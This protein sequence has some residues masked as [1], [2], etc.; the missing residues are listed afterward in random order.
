MPKIKVY[1]THENCHVLIHPTDGKLSDEGS[2]WEYDPFTARLLDTND[3]TRDTARAH[4]FAADKR[5]DQSK[6]PAHATYPE[7]VAATASDDDTES[8]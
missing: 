8:N 4:K 7:P 1:P 6:P 2:L 3:L 5:Q